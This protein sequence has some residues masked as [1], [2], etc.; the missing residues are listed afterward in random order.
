MGCC[1]LFLSIIGLWVIL[2]VCCGLPPLGSFIL[3]AI[4]LALAAPRK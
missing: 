4:V 3:A 2:T 1:M